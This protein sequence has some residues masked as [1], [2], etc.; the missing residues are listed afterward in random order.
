MLNKVFQAACDGDL[1]IFKGT[2]PPPPSQISVLMQFWCL[3]VTA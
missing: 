1:P 2:V 3:I